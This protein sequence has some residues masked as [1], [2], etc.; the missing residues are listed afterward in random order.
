LFE[1]RDRWWTRRN[2]S[3]LH[4]HRPPVP[5]SSHELEAQVSFGACCCK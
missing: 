2:V 4:C 3:H 5:R 1:F